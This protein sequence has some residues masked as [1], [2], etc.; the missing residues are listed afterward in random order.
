VDTV[1]SLANGLDQRVRALAR[2]RPIV[3]VVGALLVGFL[4]ARL[5]SRRRW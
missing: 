1:R 5:V 4:T 2:E 3:S